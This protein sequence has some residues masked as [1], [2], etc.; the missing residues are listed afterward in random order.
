MG[1]HGS[2]SHAP[3]VDPQTDSESWLT[4]LKVFTQHQHLRMF[5][6]WNLTYLCRAD[7]VVWEVL[8]SLFTVLAPLYWLLRKSTK[9]KYSRKCLCCLKLLVSSDV[10]VHYDTYKELISACDASPHGVGV[11]LSHWMPD[12]SE[13]PT[14]FVSRTLSSTDQK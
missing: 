5:Q 11:V 2:W 9:Q 7:V 8:P 14:G 1:L 6:N 13:R 4:R 12:G 3:T 10:L